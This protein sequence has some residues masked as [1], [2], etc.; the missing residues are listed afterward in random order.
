MTDPG[1]RTA[2]AEVPSAPGRPQRPA[3]P[4]SLLSIDVE[5][6]PADA[7]RIF[8]LGALRCDAGLID[9]SRALSLGTRRTAPAELQTRLDALSV[10]A[11]FLV[12]H[13]LKRHDRPALEAQFPGLAL[14]GLPVLDTLEL[15]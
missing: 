4:G 5:T 1:L 10:G 11:Q 7:N 13:N 8:L 12:G 6:N 3:W 15:S 9:E 2:A 14:L